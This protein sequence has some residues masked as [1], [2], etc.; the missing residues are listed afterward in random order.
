[1]INADTARRVLAL[2]AV[3]M[4]TV[5]LTASSINAGVIFA[6]SFENPI[7]SGQWVISGFHA[8]GPWPGC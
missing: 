3:A 6:E 8:D 5:T 2:A 1:M 4:V 7:I